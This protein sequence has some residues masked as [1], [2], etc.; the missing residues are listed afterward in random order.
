MVRDINDITY[1]RKSSKISV[2]KVSLV[3]DFITNQ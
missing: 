1:P 2:C 3:G